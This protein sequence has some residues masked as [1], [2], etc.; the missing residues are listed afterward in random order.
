MFGL[1]ER[2]TRRPMTTAAQRGDESE[3]VD[4]CLGS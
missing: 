2:E 3:R 1:P 4:S